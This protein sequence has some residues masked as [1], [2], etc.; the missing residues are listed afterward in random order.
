MIYI[1]SDHAGFHLKKEIIA[2]LESKGADF[3]EYGCMDAESFDYPLAAEETCTALLS[4]QTGSACGI[5]ICGTGIGISMAANKMKGIR[6]ALVTNEFTAEMARLHND[7]N[8][9]CLG[10]RVT[11]AGVAISAV[12]KYLETEFE[13]GRHARRVGQ[14]MHIEASQTEI[15]Q[16]EA[17]QGDNS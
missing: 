16:S 2:Y 9:I 17:G 1:G 11:G 14:I 10:E 13:G 15:S 7:A 12:A 5:L 8:V 6:A 3:K 4:D